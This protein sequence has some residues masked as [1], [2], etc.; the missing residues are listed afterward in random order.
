V[1]THL[2]FGPA[3]HGRPVRNDFSAVTSAVVASAG[4]D[5]L[6]GGWP[7]LYGAG[8]L[9]PDALGLAIEDDW[10]FAP[11]RSHTTEQ[12]AT[13]PSGGG[14]G[15]AGSASSWSARCRCSHG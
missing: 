10:Y 6:E 15:A 7:A 13:W 8:A 12:A 9:T 14:P 4:M 11:E 1:G 2:P 5:G 3:W